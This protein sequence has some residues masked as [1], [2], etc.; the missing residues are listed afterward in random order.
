[1]VVLRLWGKSSSNPS[2]IKSLDPQLI[3]NISHGFLL[4]P[5]A[6]V[7]PFESLFSLV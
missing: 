3:A 2:Y 4:G 1:M 5:K 7:M 6:D